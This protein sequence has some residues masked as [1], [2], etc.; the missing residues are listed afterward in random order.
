M[1]EFHIPTAFWVAVNL[2]ILYVALRK[3]LFKP[4]TQHM[5]NRTKSIKDSIQHAE[6]SK[7][8]AMELKKKYEEQLRDSKLEAEKI[9]NDA[10]AR[11]NNEYSA[12]VASARKEAEDIVQRGKEE[13]ERER[14][15]M[16]KGIKTQVAGLALAAASKVIEANMDNENNKK[17]VNKFIDEVGAA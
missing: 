5:E 2:I 4:V 7:A 3:F 17:L 6:N 12:I 1:L 9:I 11:A 13:V 16:V 14:Q 15:Q 10:K 8:E